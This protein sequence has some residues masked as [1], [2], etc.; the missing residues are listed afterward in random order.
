[1][2][3]RLDA[4]SR[5]TAGG[6]LEMVLDCTTIKLFDPDGGRSL[7]YTG[8]GNGTG[9]KAASAAAPA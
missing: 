4:D 2:V 5:A 1:V 8:T 7:T 6:E 3:A 9:A